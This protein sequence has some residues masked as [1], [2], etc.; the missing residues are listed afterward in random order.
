MKKN[1][2]VKGKIY[3]G[4]DVGG[5]KIFTGLLSE[6]GQII[7]TKKA[8]TPHTRNPRHTVREIADLVKE[9]L[10]E[11]SY[12]Q[13]DLRG[14]GIA[15]PGLVDSARGN[16]LTTPNMNLSGV[17]IVKKLEEKFNTRVAV[18]NDADLGTLGERWLGAARKM[19]NV[20]GLFAGT[21]LG[22]GIIIDGKLFSGSHGAAAEIGHM[23]I[24]RNGPKCSCGNRGCLEAFVGRWA[25]E[26][27]IRNSIKK[28]TKTIITKLLKKKKTRVIKSKILSKAFNKKDPLVRS[29]LTD[30]AKTLGVACIT[31]RHIFDPE[32]IVLG[33]GLVEACGS[34]FIPIVQKTAYADPFYSKL[35]SCKIVEAELGDNAIII[36]AVALIRQKL[37][38]A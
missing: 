37:Q 12:S 29:V 24:E 9:L 10:S 2:A 23:T 11:N 5:T 25:I 35:P 36:G 3:A 14:I 1:K 6:S 17:P 8:S 38:S 18:G 31:L 19:Q 21:G 26:R 4:I 20:I 7:D 13:K 30:A 15:I 16:I 34:F 28:G 22:G 27:D 32:V 33:G